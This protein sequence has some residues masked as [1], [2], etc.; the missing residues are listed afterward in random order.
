M[1][2]LPTTDR[3]ELLADGLGIDPGSYAGREADAVVAMAMVAGYRRLERSD[4]AQLLYV[5]RDK[6]HF[7]TSN[8]AFFAECQS[9]VVMMV[10]NPV[11]V[12]ASLSNGE[13]EA[14]IT[15][16]RKTSTYLTWLGFSSGGSLF[17]GKLR[18]LLAD[19]AKAAK[20]LRPNSASGLLVLGTAAQTIAIASLGDLQAE[21]KRRGMLGTMTPL[22]AEEFGR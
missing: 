1:A 16:W 3:A 18:Q 2:D 12:P 10:A 17:G 8:P 6:M 13:L 20:S 15:M 21:A 5:I 4:Q 14:E 22:H 11:W 7:G 9:A 19:P